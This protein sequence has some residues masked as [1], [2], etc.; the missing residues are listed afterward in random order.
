[1][2]IRE[3]AASAERPHLPALTLPP[4]LLA[5]ACPSRDAAI[6]AGVDVTKGHHDPTVRYNMGGIPTNY[7]G[8]VVTLGKDGNPGP[9]SACSPP[10]SA[11]PPRCTAPA[12]SAPTAG[13][14]RLR[15]RVRQ[16]RRG[17]AGPRQAAQADPR[18][19]GEP[20]SHPG[21]RAPHQRGALDASV[22]K[23]M[24]RVMQDD[25]VFRRGRR[26]RRCEKIDEV[27]SRR[28]TSRS[29]TARSS[30]TRTSSRR[31]SCTT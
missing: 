2:E 10:A 17:D 6:F 3:G 26:W 21:R 24:Q 14:R 19:R 22:R 9:S 31:S 5:D 27:A 1:M 4:E 16:H 29:R 23:P 8:E 25:A 28:T 30:G 7:K 20:R 15:A 11:P 18:G 12:A 13:H